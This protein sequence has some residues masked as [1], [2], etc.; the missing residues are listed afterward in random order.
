MKPFSLSLLKYYFF[1]LRIFVSRSMMEF[2][3][4]EK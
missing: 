2:E 4:V 3:L 1:H